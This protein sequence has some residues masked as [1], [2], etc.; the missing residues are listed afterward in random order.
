MK[1]LLTIFLIAAAFAVSWMPSVSSARW[2]KEPDDQLKAVDRLLGQ[3]DDAKT[4]QDYDKAI[5]LYG[6]TIAACEEFGKI[7]PNEMV[8]LIKF[9]T[10]YCRNQLVALLAA[11]RKA[12]ASSGKPLPPNVRTP[13]S[14]KPM[15]T[16]A[17][18]PVSQPDSTRQRMLAKTIALCR[19][20]RYAEAENSAREIL[21]RNKRDG[22]G[23]LLLGTAALGP[24]RLT[25]ALTELKLSTTLMP[26][27][28]EA[29]Y[30]LA[31]LLIRVSPPDIGGARS[32]YQQAVE[33]GAARDEELEV[34]LD[35]VME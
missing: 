18:R 11:R 19:E 10:G 6:A 34:V 35:L 13:K 9:R 25:E 33:L 5:R 22:L 17:N 2:R 4:E 32:C 12:G 16:A 30:N 29:H 14:P 8:N 21:A 7:F 28:Q 27:S 24:G 3:A 20:E 1:K 23:H 15:I 31:Q 26:N